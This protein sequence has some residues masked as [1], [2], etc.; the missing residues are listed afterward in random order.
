MDREAWCAVVHGVAKSQIG[1]SDW[2]QLNGY[3]CLSTNKTS[4]HKSLVNLT[5]E[6]VKNVKK[7]L[8]FPTQWG[9]K[10]KELITKKIPEPLL[11]KNIQE[12]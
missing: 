9:G 10:K 5:W 6:M 1:L 8:F 12:S 7:K 4:I 3:K 11:P 2:T